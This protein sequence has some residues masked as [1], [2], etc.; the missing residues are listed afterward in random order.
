M[1]LFLG[2]ATPEAVLT[3]VASE[4]LA[5]VVHRAGAAQQAGLSFSPNSGLRAFGL[6]RE[7]EVRLPFAHRVVHP[8]EG[9]GQLQ[10]GRLDG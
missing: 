2:L 4:H 5:F 8:V 10:F 7:E 9:S 3:V 1:P 6:G